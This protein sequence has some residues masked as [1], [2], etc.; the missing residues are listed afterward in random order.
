M[1]EYKI[2][3]YQ[4]LLICLHGEEDSLKKIRLFMNF[5]SFHVFCKR[6]SNVDMEIMPKIWGGGEYIPVHVVVHHVLLYN[7]RICVLKR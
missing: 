2:M 3:G 7:R 1:H 5:I 4:A 6:F